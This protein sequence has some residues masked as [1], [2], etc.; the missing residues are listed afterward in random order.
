MV[1][2]SIGV[3]QLLAPAGRGRVKDP[4]GRQKPLVPE[5]PCRDRMGVAGNAHRV[6]R[7]VHGHDGFGVKPPRGVLRGGGLV[8]LAE[9]ALVHKRE[10]RIIK[11]VLQKPQARALPDLVELVMHRN[12]GSWASGISGSG[13]SGSS[14]ATQA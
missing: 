5:M 9:S 3:A 12:R 4:R 11:R 13:S 8:A 7:I 10:V 14:S 1:R 2:S 6:G